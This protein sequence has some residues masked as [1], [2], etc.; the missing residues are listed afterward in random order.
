MTNWTLSLPGFE[1][2]RISGPAKRDLAD[3]GAYTLRKWGG[4]QK[5]RYLAQIREGFV[6]LQQTPG[7]GA[8]RE[9]IAV[10]LRAYPVGEHVVYYRETGTGLVVIRVLHRS[11]D[12]ELQFK[13]NRERS[14]DDPL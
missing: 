4:A 5:K 13:R 3:I 14:E 8:P 10:G 7:I 11:M 6:A 12:P 9:G 2:L 1:I